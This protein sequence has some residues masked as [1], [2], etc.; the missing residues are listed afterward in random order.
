V[1]LVVE[2]EPMIRMVL[3]EVLMD[4]GFE[5]VEAK[6]GAEAR[7]RFGP[8]IDLVLLD[9][10]LPDADGLE[11]LGEFKQTRPDCVVVMMTGHGVLEV[12]ERA[13][14]LGA[15]HFLHKP[16]DVDLLGTFLRGVVP[17]RLVP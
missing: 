5:V 15:D 2:D 8:R 12:E 1:I 6:D 10:R 4:D 13:T 7:V 17:A 11:L 9:I 14:R 16:F 3:R